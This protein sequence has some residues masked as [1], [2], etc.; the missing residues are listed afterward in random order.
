MSFYK[1]LKTMTESNKI[2]SKISKT[3]K[4]DSNEISPDNLPL[5]FVKNYLRV[6]HDLDDAEIKLMIVSAQSYV[7]NLLKISKEE[8]IED[9]ELV[10][11]MLALV[12]Y[13]YENKTVTMKAN[14]KI[15][16]MFESILGLHRREIL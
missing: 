12:A 6:D 13:F 15:E 4:R 16:L 11:P 3:I 9:V 14:E 1:K 7:R 2:D 8:P 5:E 10:I